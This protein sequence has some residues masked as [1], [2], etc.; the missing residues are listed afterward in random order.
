MIGLRAF[1]EYRFSFGFLVLGAGLA[2]GMARALPLWLP[3]AP[4]TE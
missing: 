2:Y 3:P 4:W 1:R